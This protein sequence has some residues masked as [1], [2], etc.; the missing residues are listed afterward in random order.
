MD[1]GHKKSAQALKIRL[2]SLNQLDVWFP[3]ILEESGDPAWLYIWDAISI[4]LDDF[5]GIVTAHD[6]WIYPIGKSRRWDRIFDRWDLTVDPLTE[7]HSDKKW[8]T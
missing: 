5:K 7:T 6:L 2:D 1:H 3:L 8:I 4:L